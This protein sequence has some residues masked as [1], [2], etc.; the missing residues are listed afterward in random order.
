V[1]PGSAPQTAHLT[2]AEDI[3]GRDY[4]ANTAV[5]VGEFDPGQLP[6]E[7]TLLDSGIGYVRVHTFFADPVMITSAWKLALTYLQ[8]AGATGLIVD[9]R[10]HSGGLMPTAL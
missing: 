5:S 8:D 3:D 10:D 2:L 9:V 4:A 1:N 7:A 6:V